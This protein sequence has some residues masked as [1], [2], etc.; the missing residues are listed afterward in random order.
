MGGNLADD[1][2]LAW[3]QI[4]AIAKRL[5]SPHADKIYVAKDYTKEDLRKDLIAIIPPR[6][7]ESA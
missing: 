1:D 7:T 4:R 2:V 5:E 6:F 3:D